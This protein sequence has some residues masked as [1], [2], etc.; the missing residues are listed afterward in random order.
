[1]NMQTKVLILMGSESDWTVMKE[2]YEILKRFE[3]GV[4]GLQNV[5]NAVC[6]LGMAHEIGCDLEGG[7]SVVRP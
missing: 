1:M 7:P 4:P 2:A 3:I 6:A 5:S